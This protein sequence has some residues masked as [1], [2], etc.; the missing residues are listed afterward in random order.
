MRSSITDERARGC[1][2]ASLLAAGLLVAAA[3]A[4]A[5]GEVVTAR[6]DSAGQ[7]HVTLRGE[8]LW[9]DAELGGFRGEPEPSVAPGQIHIL[10]I[11]YGIECPPPPPPPWVRPPPVP[12]QFNV[13]LG[14]LPEGPYDVQ[15]RIDRD[16]FPPSSTLLSTTIQ[17]GT[18]V[19]IPL[20]LSVASGWIV[21]GVLMLGVWALRRRQRLIAARVSL[22]SRAV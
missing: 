22:W 16:G 19:L 17:V 13:N 15:W 8:F 7:V 21:G 2:L 14:V 3:N 5:F 12:Y 9:C 10:S 6:Q 4:H 11:S 20:P 18:P 1:A